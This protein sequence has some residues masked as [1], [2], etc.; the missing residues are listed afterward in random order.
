MTM[1]MTAKLQT[2]F[3]AEMQQ[4]RSLYAQGQYLPCFRRLERAHI[5]GQRHYIPHV[6]NHYWMLKVGLRRRD[7][8]E[9]LGQTLR[10]IGSAGSLI[11]WIPT[12]NTG[13]ANVSPIKPMP[14][15]ADL[16]HFFD[17]GSVSQS[18]NE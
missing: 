13:G 6:I 4:A 7:L 2:A 17:E 1:I 16:A 9:I 14:I 10:I 18:I 15:P 3:N 11:G 5:L 8:R 12:G